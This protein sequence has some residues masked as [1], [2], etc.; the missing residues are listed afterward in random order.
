LTPHGLD[1]AFEPEGAQLSGDGPGVGNALIPALVDQ[2]DVG[3][4]PR[5]TVLVCHLP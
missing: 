4:Q 2:V 3:I 5:W 1:V